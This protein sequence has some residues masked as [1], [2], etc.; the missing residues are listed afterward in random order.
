[1]SAVT[2]WRLCSATYAD[3]A[4]DG[5]GAKL[6]GG[7]WS[8]VGVPLAY[9]AESRALAVLEVLANADDPARLTRLAWV[10]VPAEI[11]SALIERPSRYPE[12]WAYF[13]HALASQVFGSTWVEQRRSVALRVPSAVVPGEFNY[14]LNPAHPAF[15]EVKIGKALSFDFDPRF[16]K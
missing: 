6:Y 16:G 8:P 1:V 2:V 13:P 3:T 9:A 15:K 14:L 10:L 5:E 12:T 11:D 7:R 4:Y